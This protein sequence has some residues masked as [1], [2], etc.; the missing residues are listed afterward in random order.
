M[1]KVATLCLTLFLLPL[2][3]PNFASADQDEKSDAAELLNLSETIQKVLPEGWEIDIA[4]LTS[5]IIRIESEYPV[6]V[7]RSKEKL[8][9]VDWVVSAP[10]NYKPPTK[11]RIVE[12]VLLCRPFVSQE[13][14]Q[15]LLAQNKRIEKVRQDFV[16]RNLSKVPWGHKGP[17]PLPPSAFSPR[18]DAEEK[19][20]LEYKFMWMS[21]KR[22]YLPTHHFKTLSFEKVPFWGGIKDENKR[23]AYKK[24]LTDL[25][26][27][28]APY[29]K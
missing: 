4:P 20:V 8:D 23:Q 28:L 18:N 12:I 10:P 1:F 26:T 21:A 9:V 22:N 17:R 5:G 19:T 25:D 6:L 16:T 13:E 27:I 14:Y 29:E 24:L 3:L 7:I 11:K 15:K 2:F